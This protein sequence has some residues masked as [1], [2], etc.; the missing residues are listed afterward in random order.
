M[1]NESTAFL[2]ASEAAGESSRKVIVA[3][4]S[5]TLTVVG[6]LLNSLTFLILGRSTFTTIR[7]RPTLHYMRTMAVFDTLMLYGWNLDHYMEGIHNFLIQ[8]SIMPLCRFF[9]FYNYITCQSSAWLRVFVCLDRYLALSRLHRTWLGNANH[10]LFII[11][12]IVGFFTLFNSLL[13]FCACTY[14][15]DGAIIAGSW[16]LG[17][18]FIWDYVHLGVYN[19]VPFILMVILNSGVIYHL[20]QLR[21]ATTVNNSRIQHRTISIT[22]VITTFLFLIMT[23][24]SSVAFAFFSSADA[25]VLQFTDSLLYTYHILSFPLYLLTFDEFRREFIGMITCSHNM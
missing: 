12:C 5:L 3:Y 7:P 2:S 6:T 19:C 20:I 18:T 15:S 22:L 14:G 21:R 8:T 11:A 4:F 23:V 24:P 1:P 13:F 9:T 17:T 10:V 16:T 25:N